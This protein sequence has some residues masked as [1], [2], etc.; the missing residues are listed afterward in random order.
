MSWSIAHMV[1]RRRESY[2]QSCYCR[3]KCRPSIAELLPK[4]IWK[5]LRELTRSV[6]QVAAFKFASETYE[7][8]DVWDPGIPQKV[9][10]PLPRSEA[11]RVSRLL[12]HSQ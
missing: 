10:S 3:I 9:Q 8:E 2:N 6:D 4:R 7:G 12:Q 5:N 1:A 11:R